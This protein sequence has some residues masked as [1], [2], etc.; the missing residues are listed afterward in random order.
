MRIA[1]LMSASAFLAA[2]ATSGDRGW[3]GENAQPFDGA[4]AHCEAEVA[5]MAKDARRQAFDACM[6]G[7]GWHRP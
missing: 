6:A 2:C 5:D 7:Q 4:K 3:R 1:L